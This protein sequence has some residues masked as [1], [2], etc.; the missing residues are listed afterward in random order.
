MTELQLATAT[1]HELGVFSHTTH[2][3]WSTTATMGQSMLYGV[4]F[5][6]FARKHDRHVNWSA[7]NHGPQRRTGP[8]RPAIS[9]VDP[10]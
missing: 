7:G 3:L 4:D 2:N 9:R 8:I 1:V 6:E 10:P 5:D